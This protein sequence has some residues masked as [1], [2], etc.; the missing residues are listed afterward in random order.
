M[1]KLAARASKSE[2]LR[3]LGWRRWFVVVVFMV[4]VIQSCRVVDV[5]EVGVC[6]VDVCVPY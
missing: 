5:C 3:V 4:C 2:F 6:E 1:Q